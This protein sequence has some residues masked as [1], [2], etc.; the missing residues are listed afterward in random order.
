MR[1]INLTNPAIPAR[2]FPDAASLLEAVKREGGHV[3][4]AWKGTVTY[5]DFPRAQPVEVLTEASPPIP[6][7]LLLS[8]R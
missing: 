8:R 6:I 1:L 4:A 7:Q 3:V 5:S 2:N